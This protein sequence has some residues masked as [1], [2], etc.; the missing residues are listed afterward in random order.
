MVGREAPHHFKLGLDRFKAVETPKI[1]DFR[2][3]DRSDL[4]TKH[5]HVQTYLTSEKWLRSN[6]KPWT[7]GGG[8]SRSPTRTQFATKWPQ[9]LRVRYV[10]KLDW[11]VFKSGRFPD[12][13][14]LILGVLTAL[15]RPRTHLKWWGASRPTTLNGFWAGL[16][17]FRHPKST[18]SN[19]EANLI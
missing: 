18:I 6:T 11:W 19:P 3:G 14:S 9:T 16:G 7:P 2:S 8:P 13:K 15:N 12:W 5:S 1:D 4:K 17:P 10:R